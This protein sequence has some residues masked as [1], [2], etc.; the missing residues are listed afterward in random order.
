MSLFF[1]MM[2]LSYIHTSCRYQLENNDITLRSA[3]W[4]IYKPQ[5]ILEV[6]LPIVFMYVHNNTWSL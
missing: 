5:T 6:L 3:Q 2:A 1:F 4:E